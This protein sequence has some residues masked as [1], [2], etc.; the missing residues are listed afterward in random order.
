MARII[1]RSRLGASDMEQGWA[2]WFTGLPASGKTTLARIVRRALFE[3]DIPT[4]VLASDELR[5]LML[6]QSSYAM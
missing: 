3:R 2:I 6:A 5:D 4:V 1:R